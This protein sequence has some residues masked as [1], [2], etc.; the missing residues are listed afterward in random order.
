MV[1]FA[2]ENSETAKQLAQ[3]T[4]DLKENVHYFKS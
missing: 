2:Q 1:T 4:N 3:L